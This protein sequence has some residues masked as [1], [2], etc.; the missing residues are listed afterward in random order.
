M[1]HPRRR[2][3]DARPRA[4]S[5]P[6]SEL[7]SSPSFDPN[8]AGLDESAQEICTERPV[9]ARSSKPKESLDR[10]LLDLPEELRRREWMNR[11]EVALFASPHPVPREVLAELVGGAC[12]L[13]LLLADLAAELKGRP[14]EIVAVAGGWQFRTR[15]RHADVIRALDGT[16]EK[17][18]KLSKTEMIVLTVVG[19]FQ[20]IT[21]GDISKHLGQEI[22][23]TIIA[24]LKTHGL[25]AAGPR[26]PTPGAPTTWITTRR[27]LEVYGLDG[28]QDLPDLEAFE[29]GSHI[30]D[31][32]ETS[33][34]DAVE[35]EID[36]VLGLLE[37]SED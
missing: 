5:G 31:S 3:R 17:T 15:P 8:P 29:S 19:Y 6:W 2:P 16:R 27:F 32:G 4:P 37:A 13:D 36:R 25:V 26:A 35:A 34:T 12:R 9:S 20:P 21:R 14:Y 18:P 23:R 33:A 1:S 22:H 11:V 7:E 10:E 28:L 30:L 24:A